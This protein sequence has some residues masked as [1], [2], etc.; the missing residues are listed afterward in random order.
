MALAG[1]TNASGLHRASLQKQFGSVLARISEHAYKLSIA[2][3]EGIMSAAFEVVIIP[4][5]GGSSSSTSSSKRGGLSV[6]IPSEV[7]FDSGTM[8]DAFANPAD[9]VDEAEDGGKGNVL[10]TVAL[11]LACVRRVETANDGTERYITTEFDHG[12]STNGIQRTNS[13]TSSI[14]IPAKVLD[15]TILVKPK[16]LLDSVTQYLQP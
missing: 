13:S 1:C 10:C 5:G 16:V 11:G 12:R 4:P 14:G 8:M 6:D 9:P 7:R 15:R 3:R 2:F